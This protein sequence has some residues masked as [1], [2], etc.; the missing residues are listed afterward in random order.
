MATAG[1]KE[2]LLWY[3][4]LRPL[5]V[6]VVGDFAGRELYVVHGESLIR[7]CLEQSRVDFEGNHRLG[8]FSLV[9][10]TNAI[11]AVY[12]VEKF[13]SDMHKRG[14]NF[15]VIFF[16]DSRQ[17]CIPRGAAPE[18]AYKYLLARDIILRHLS[19]SAPEVSDGIKHQV[20]EFDSLQAPAFRVYL[21][22]H[23]VHFFLYHEGDETKGPDSIALRSDIR[24]ILSMG[25]NVAIINYVEFQ[26]SKIFL[27][28][29][30]G[31]HS[32]SS[33]FGSR[34]ENVGR[35]PILNTPVLGAE[36]FVLI[37]DNLVSNAG[38][39]DLTLRDVYSATICRATQMVDNHQLASAEELVRAFLLHTAL[40]ELCPLSER[41]VPSASELAMPS[42]SLK[43]SQ[44]F[45]RHFSDAAHVL[46]SAEALE[47]VRPSS[48][49]AGVPTWDLYDLLDGRLFFYVLHGM[50][51]GQAFPTEALKRA[52]A[53][54]KHAGYSD[55]PYFRLKSI[56]TSEPNSSSTVEKNP[57][58]LPFNHPVIDKYLHGMTLDETAE[59]P[60][61]ENDVIFR[62]LT[63]WHNSKKSVLP[64]T[65]PAKKGFFARK[66]H[67]R[68]MA[69]IE[70]YSRSLTNAGGASLTRETIVVST[71][72]KREKEK[73]KASSSKG[74]AALADNAQAR[75]TR[76]Q[77][78]Q[79]KKK[80]GGKE[81][82]HQEARLRQE[83]KDEKK[84]E[85]VA[86]HWGVT[87]ASLETDQALTPLSRYLKAEALVPRSHWSQDGIALG[88]EVELYLCH[89]LGAMWQK[90]VSSPRQ[91]Q[92]GMFLLSL[93]WTWL[94][95][96]RH[97]PINKPVQQ[98]VREISSLLGTPSI[99]M[100]V[101]S[102]SRPNLSFQFNYA[103][104][105][106]AGKLV[107]DYMALQ[108]EYGGPYMDRRFDPQP[109][110]RV[111]FEPDAW[112]RQVLD[113]ID[114]KDSSLLVIAPTS[115]GKTFISFYAMKKV[116][117]ESDD[118]V[119][120][121]VAPTKALVN[122][123]AAEINGHFSKSY[124]E[125][126][127][128]SVYAIHTR[129]YRVNNPTGCQILVTVPHVLQIMLLSPTN[130]VG[131][132]AWSKRI[133]RIVFDEVHCI[134]QSE[135][136]VIW[137]Q[138]LLMAPCPIIA[139]SATVGNRDEF[140]DWL[141]MS[142]ER[143]G[144]QLKMVV[145]ETRYSELRKFIYVGEGRIEK[146]MEKPQALPVPGLDEGDY[147]MTQ[148]GSSSNI[149]FLNPVVAFS[150]RN[151]DALG[152]ISFEARDLY[153]LWRTI[154]ELLTADERKELGV[155]DPDCLPPII[156]KSDV[157]CWEIK[158]KEVLRRLIDSK[159]SVFNELRSRFESSSTPKPDRK[160]HMHTLPKLAE[161]L[162]RRDA[163]PALVF[164]YDR[165]DCEKCAE[166]ILKQLTT[167]EEAWKTTSPEW[168]SKLQKFKDWKRAQEKLPIRSKKDNSSKVKSK[169]TD[170]EKVS[171]LD[172]LRESSVEHSPW[173]RFDENAPLEAFSFADHSKL[174]QS[175]FDEI[176]RPLLY[177]ESFELKPWMKLCLGRGIGVH[178][179]GLNRRYRQVVEMLFRRGF[180]RLVIATGTLAMGINMP[181]KTVIFS[182]DSIF[183]TAQNYRQSSG[184]AGRR[185]FD[186]LGNVVFNGIDRQRVYEIMASRLP[187]LRGQFPISTTLVLR[188]LGLLHGTN[189]SDF[190]V[191]SVDALLSQT[192]LYLGG[193]E[194]ED[195]VRH[196]LRFSIEYLRR[197]HLLS[198]S[199]E[200]VNFAGLA[201]HLYFTENSVFAFHSLLK[202]GYFHR[203]CEGIKTDPENTRLQMVLVLSH[204]FNRLPVKRTAELVEVAHRSSSVVFLPRLPLE[205]ETL[206]IE[207]NRETLS[208]FEGYVHSYISHNLS[209]RPDR[210]LP[211]T[212]TDII[213]GGGKNDFTLRGQASPS[214]VRSPFAALSGFDDSFTSIHDLCATVRDGV[215]LEESAIPYIPIWP[216]DDGA[217][218]LNAYIYDFYKHGSMDVLMRD[219]RIKGGDV[220]FLLKDFWLTLS[221][222]VTGLEAIISGKDASDAH[223]DDDEDDG[224]GMHDLGENED[225]AKA[226]ATEELKQQMEDDAAAA[227]PKPKGR[228]AERRVKD[229]WDESD[230]DGDGE[231]S[232]S[233]PT[234]PDASGSSDN[235]SPHGQDD[236]DENGS[237]LTVLEAFTSL[238]D[239]FMDKFRKVWA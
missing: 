6:D 161:E 21:E 238:R 100:T 15:D 137:E 95:S 209:D 93:V 71:P 51:A 91:T 216:V 48:N 13:L 45:I 204:L 59:E 67:Q 234:I 195:S 70:A 111:S 58:V 119:L 198:A 131:P 61:R 152:D 19:R 164:N 224:D 203:L 22:K 72:P 103:P 78:Q 158:M 27:P 217:L 215:F 142:Q 143:K 36:D 211:F 194:A 179:A 52:G 177:Q 239:D 155:P 169:E 42:E 160:S 191:R 110:S 184:R 14:C 145:H 205:A 126:A 167:A 223:D 199:G 29:L 123:I 232:P 193:P 26:S 200:P 171:K 96:S 135:D 149:Q 66:Y 186:L 136:G 83:K 228:K 151:K 112:Q 166:V 106:R 154:K 50:K 89:V 54:I 141:A 144:Y 73:A 163:L 230:D 30:S 81:A 146:G 87:V 129:D 132:N 57:S 165:V 39:P 90:T 82:A 237:L 49:E 76:M 201:S 84:R 226:I 218:E 85:D 92:D 11:H 56:A 210:T 187:A 157:I 40:L 101:G 60:G 5:K 37:A 120:V 74:K 117:E 213:G 1:E 104:F 219:N 235:G 140:R 109:D 20:Q 108:L 113:S 118:A 24:H 181:C 18:N 174:Q 180:L 62:D 206:L 75:S 94:Q 63:H 53:L 41:R 134:G 176:V 65:L 31:S 46:L 9:S 172:L 229:S 207:H 189:N 236:D 88:G 12:A 220:W 3:S 23:A 225:E 10:S 8:L 156:A 34:V 183:L 99:P 162:N 197:Q 159:I 115:A 150:D 231:F 233:E 86:R 125:K 192:R 55:E 139:L 182:G 122:Q 127:G 44:K 221:T 17:L 202:G 107:G 43:E 138:L 121:Y 147:G 105:E 64:K 32:H 208:I 97:G 77:K 222:I 214:V 68:L 148:D 35:T 4:G 116:L 188:L 124:H 196:H 98:A 128:K 190:A 227:G 133:K 47:E 38:L 79:G 168:A 153:A 16:Y 28:L 114:S 130:A 25:I 7:H 173:E 178:H 212:R 102:Q 170:G 33:T 185:G 175:D 80:V 2:L 69:D